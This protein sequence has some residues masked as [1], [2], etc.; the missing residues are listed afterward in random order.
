[1]FRERVRVGS[2]PAALAIGLVLLSACAVK[3]APDYDKSVV[4]GLG[5]VNEQMMTFF[6]SVSGGTQAET[7]DQRQDTYNT[8][9]GKLEAIKIQADARPEPRSFLSQVYGGGETPASADDVEQLKAPTGAS[10]TEMVEGMTTMRDTDR[11]QG[12]TPIE[13]TAFKQS[14][15]ISM[16]QALTYEK[17]LER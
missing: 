15:M 13:V 4:D 17:A 7:F 6:A 5:A 1:M 10:I 12:L 16:D 9:I 3:L 2:W 11:S 8:V 14:I